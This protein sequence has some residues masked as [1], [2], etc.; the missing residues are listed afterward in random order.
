MFEVFDVLTTTLF[1]YQRE[2][3]LEEKNAE[4]SGCVSIFSS[5]CSDIN[6]NVVK[7]RL[8][9]ETAETEQIDTTDPKI[10]FNRD[11]DLPWSIRPQWQGRSLCRPRNQWHGLP[12]LVSESNTVTGH[13]KARKLSEICAHFELE[14]MLLS[15]SDDCALHT[16]KEKTLL[17]ME[18]CG[19]QDSGESARSGRLYCDDLAPPVVAFD[20]PGCEELEQPQPEYQLQDTTS[21]MKHPKNLNYQ[22]KGALARTSESK[23]VANTLVTPGPPSQAIPGK[24]QSPKL[25]FKEV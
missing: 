21:R 10:A 15:E 7:R 12:L 22:L 24:F 6:I 3:D 13:G 8:E 11:L 18:S 1:V 25:A 17:P 2:E 20:S 23:Y 9:E 5:M 16:K 19:V 4:R 14:S